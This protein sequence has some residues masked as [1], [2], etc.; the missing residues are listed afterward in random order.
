MTLTGSLTVDGASPT[1]SVKPN[2]RVYFLLSVAG[3]DTFSGV[4]H[5]ER[6]PNGVLWEDIIS[7]TGD[8]VGA[9]DVANDVYL[10]ETPKRQYYRARVSAVT[11]DALAYD[12]ES[13][14]G[15]V[16]EIILRDGKGRPILGVT[17]DGG[18]DIL[19]GPLGVANIRGAS[20][21]DGSQSDLAIAAA[22]TYAAG[23]RQAAG[24]VEELVDEITIAAADVTGTSAGQFGH[25]AGYPLVA[26]PGADAMVELISALAVYDR[27]TATYGAGGNT[28]IN[29]N[30][31][32]AITGLISAANFAGAAAD[33]VALFVP[34]AV[35]AEAI[36]ANKGLNLVSSGAFTNPGT[37]AGVIRVRVHYRVHTLGLA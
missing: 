21:N 19:T 28:T 13:V 15:D 12:I 20:T 11:G 1:L 23:V 33:K 7:Y 14:I 16:V 18:V 10:N 27:D 24:N 36:A 31:G 6:S 25:A 35:A 3:G 8:Q 4:I 32:A 26:D 9:V 2:E 34:L 22:T 30:G 29:R 17:D 5:I 37:A